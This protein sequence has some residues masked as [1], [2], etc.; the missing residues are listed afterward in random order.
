[1][2]SPAVLAEGHGSRNTVFQS[3]MMSIARTIN[4]HM[5]VYHGGCSLNTIVTRRIRTYIHL[6]LSFMF[7]I[8]RSPAFKSLVVKTVHRDGRLKAATILLERQ[9]ASVHITLF[10][11]LLD[12]ISG[13]GFHMFLREAR[14][15]FP[16][17]CSPTGDVAITAVL[18]STASMN[19]VTCLFA[20]QKF[21][22]LNSRR[23]K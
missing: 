1:M 14:F 8:V 22:F 4:K 2:F 23:G 9:M 6:I 10:R 11:A 12:R 18:R 21:I 20:D 13:T 15:V 17:G 19:G 16:T 5:S 3:S 7:C